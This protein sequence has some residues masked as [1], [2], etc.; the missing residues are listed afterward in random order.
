[1]CGDR[2]ALFWL[3]LGYSDLRYRFARIPHAFFSGQ[4]SRVL[5]HV[6]FYQISRKS[7]QMIHYNHYEYV[8][9]SFVTLIQNKK[10][11]I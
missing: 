7:T 2:F 11:I 1:M 5:Y 3:Y 9:I 4:G 6:W 10:Y 8:I